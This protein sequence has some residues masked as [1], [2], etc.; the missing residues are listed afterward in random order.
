LVS[1]LASIGKSA[2]NAHHLNV[3][4]PTLLNSNDDLSNSL[5]NDTQTEL[6]FYLTELF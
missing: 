2:R 4:K 3:F 1:A 6:T 5:S